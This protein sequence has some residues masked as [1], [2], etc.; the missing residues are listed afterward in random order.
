MTFKKCTKKKYR[1]HIYFIYFFGNM[2]HF[3]LLLARSINKSNIIDSVLDLLPVKRDV[4]SPSLLSEDDVDS[5]LAV[6]LLQFNSFR[7]SNGL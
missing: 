2:T 6:M 1:K 5:V 3:T 7:S 4:T